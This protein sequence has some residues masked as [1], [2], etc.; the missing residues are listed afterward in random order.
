MKIFAGQSLLTLKLD[1]GTDVSTA[2]V[3]RILYKKPSGAQGAWD[4]T[5]VEALTI[6]TYDVEDNDLDEQGHWRFQAYVEIGGL[7]GYGQVVTEH[8][9]LSVNQQ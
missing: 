1:T 2:T 4:A 5:S 8:V 6:L 7:K 3:K 9:Q